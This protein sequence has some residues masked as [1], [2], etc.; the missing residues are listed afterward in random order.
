MRNIHAQ[1]HCSSPLFHY[2]GVQSPLHSITSNTLCIVVL[3]LKDEERI[4]KSCQ[5]IVTPNS[6]LHQASQIIDGLWYMVTRN[7]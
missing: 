3:F 1:D 6:I 4:K 5:N 2:C 7:H